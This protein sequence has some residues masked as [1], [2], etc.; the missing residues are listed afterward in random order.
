MCPCCR[1]VDFTRN[2][3]KRTRGAVVGLRVQCENRDCYWTGQLIDL[4]SHISGKCPYAPE[5]GVRSFTSSL[6]LTTYTVINIIIKIVHD[7]TLHVANTCVS[8]SLYK[9]YNNT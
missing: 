5:L 3:D 9:V 7:R 1:T 8:L 2:L 4:R 6:L